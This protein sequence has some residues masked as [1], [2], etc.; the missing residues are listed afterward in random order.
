MRIDDNSAQNLEFYIG[1]GSNYHY[2]TK[3]HG[4]TAGNWYHVAGSY[5]GSTFNLYV[6]G[7]NI[8]SCSDVFTPNWGTQTLGIGGA[9]EY[10]GGVIDS[11]RVWGRALTPSE[12][13]SNYNAGNVELQTRVGSDTSP[14][15]GSWEAWRPVTNETVID[16]LDNPLDIA[17]P[18]A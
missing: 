7:K 5:D 1:D 18:S 3:P 10:W 2:C 17:T 8:G 9:A 12:I 4:M 11:L 6:N 13:M 15:D 14:D 16:N